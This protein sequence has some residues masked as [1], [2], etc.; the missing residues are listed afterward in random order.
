MEEMQRIERRGSTLLSAAQRDDVRALK[1]AMRLGAPA[2]YGNRAGQTALHIACL[3]GNF[4][5]LDPLIEAGANLNA[6][7]TISGQTPLHMCASGRGSAAGRLKCAQ[8]MVQAGA[9]VSVQDD[10]GRMPCQITRDEAI[11]KF[12]T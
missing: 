4:M 7:N 10:G 1:M 2:T 3:W 12:L 5:C 9:N 6:K 11:R 8:K